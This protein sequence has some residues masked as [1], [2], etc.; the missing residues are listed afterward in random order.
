MIELVNVHTEVVW[1][2]FSISEVATMN[3]TLIRVI[4][5]RLKLEIV[6]TLELPVDINA[7]LFI[8]LLQVVEFKN[9]LLILIFWIPILA[10]ET[11]RNWKFV[12]TELMTVILLIQ[13]FTAAKLP[14]PKLNN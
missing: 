7:I 14:K 13:I 8:E 4:L 1:K 10:E 3:Y 6:G 2:V 12:K 9:I 11:E 5:F